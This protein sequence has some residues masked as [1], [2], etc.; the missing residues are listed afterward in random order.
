VHPQR[1][2][3]M[4]IN[5]AQQLNPKKESVFVTLMLWKKSGEK[6]TDDELVPVTKVGVTAAGSVEVKMKNGSTHFD[7]N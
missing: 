5:T 1:K 6:W 2:E 4:V 3:S 7:L